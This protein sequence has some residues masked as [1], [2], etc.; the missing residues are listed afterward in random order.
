MVLIGPLQI[1]SLSVK[2]ILDRLVAVF[3]LQMTSYSTDLL[4]EHS[5]VEPGLEL[6]TSSRGGSDASCIL[7][8]SYD[9]IRFGRGDDGTVEWRLR[10]VGLDD[11]EVLGIVYLEAENEKNH[12]KS[13]HV[14]QNCVQKRTLAVL[15]LLDVM[16]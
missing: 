13:I 2:Q 6:S 16:K 12:Q 5:V 11:L 1:S 10:G 8:T 9:D 7:S 4:F 15:S 14:E 3:N